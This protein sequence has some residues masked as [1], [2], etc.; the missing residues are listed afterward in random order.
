MLAA[1][2]HEGSV[3]SEEV[4]M[5]NGGVVMPAFGM[6]GPDRAAY[7]PIAAAHPDRVVVQV[8][9]PNLRRRRR[10]HPLHHAAAAG[11]TSAVVE[12]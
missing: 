5:T 11:L 6:E 9:I 7:E 12:A 8:P 1:E 2:R 10:R 4:F 3:G